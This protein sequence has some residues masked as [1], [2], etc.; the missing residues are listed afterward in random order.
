MFLNDVKRLDCAL[1]L[2]TTRDNIA[3]VYNPKDITEVYGF[4]DET[5]EFID[6]YGLFTHD[7]LQVYPFS[8][9]RW[10]DKGI[11]HLMRLVAE[12][13]K[14]GVIARM[15]FVN[16]HC[17][18]KGDSKYTDAMEAYAKKIGVEIDKD[19]IFTYRFA[20]A[21]NRKEWRYSV[22][23][24]VVRELN[25]ISNMFIFPSAS[26]CCSLIQAEASIA[27]KF[28]VLNRD[29]IPMQEFCT[30]DVLSYQFTSNN[31]D[32]EKSEY[33]TCVAREVWAEIRT[34]SA[35]MNSTRARN[36]TYNRDHIFRTQFEP[37]I[38]KRYKPRERKGEIRVEPKQVAT[39]PSLFPEIGSDCS[40][41]GECTEEGMANCKKQAGRCMAIDGD[42]K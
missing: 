7:L 10:T 15:V 5:K 32:D 12:W 30:P 41:W 8:T 21:T 19:V 29:F 26:E 22:P 37:L 18:S 2:Q 39:E 9:T 31:P 35:I 40:I 33:Y 23:S 36:Q 38:W 14:Q 6:H 3:V 28:M 17:N 42:I 4:C 34:E 25:L 20:D 13:K 16:A 24:R 27:G 1:M 11:K